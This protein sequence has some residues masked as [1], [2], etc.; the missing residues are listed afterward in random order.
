MSLDYICDYALL[1]QVLRIDILK[2]NILVAF[3]TAEHLYTFV[4]KCVML[5]INQQLVKD[6]T[7]FAQH[8]SSTEV[9][10]EHILVGLQTL[11]QASRLGLT[12]VLCVI[13][14]VLLLLH[15]LS[16]PVN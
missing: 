4:Q 14:P 10:W 9:W 15:T 13:E 7:M 5:K 1:W 12:G 16:T 6:S 2:K 11:L 3:I 8:E